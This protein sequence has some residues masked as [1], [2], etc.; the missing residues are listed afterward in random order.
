MR[1]AWVSRHRPVK[2]ELDELRR[3]GYTDVVQISKTYGSLEEVIADIKMA[4]A[5]AGVVVLP[6]SMIA[7]LLPLAKREGI[8]LLWAEML[9]PERHR[10]PA[11]M[12]P[13]PSAC[14]EFDPDRDVWMP[15]QGGGYG[16]HVRFSRFME[17]KDIKLELAP[18]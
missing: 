11:D 13:G 18:L 9:P 4:R 8:R 14:E 2:A 3:L 17:I 15:A 6:L 5:D 10:G 1:V 12:C 16:R 7:R